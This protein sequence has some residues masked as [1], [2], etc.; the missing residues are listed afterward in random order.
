MQA[1]FVSNGLVFML[2]MFAAGV[3]VSAQ[4]PPAETIAEALSPLPE[5]LREG[6]T[7]R[8]Y[9][10]SG[11][12]VTLRQ[13]A[14]GITC[15]ADNPKVEGY[16]VACFR[17]GLEPLVIRMGELAARGLDQTAV[18]STIAAEVASGALSV[19][20]RSAFYRRIGADA[21]SARHL[22]VLFIPGATAE[23]TGLQTGPSQSSP[24]LMDAG[25]PGAHIMIWGGPER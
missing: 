25:T 2:T 4:R 18:R 9:G 10:P 1:R 23:S 14:S 24:W 12:L 20:D 22:L 7:V 5:S 11:E 19:P 8:A 13:G 6:V 17:Q 3:A 16:E 15:L 21:A